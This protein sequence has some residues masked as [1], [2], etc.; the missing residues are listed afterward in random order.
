MIKLFKRLGGHKVNKQTVDK[1][2]LLV[3]AAGR[4]VQ[5]ARDNL[6]K[7]EEIYDYHTRRY[8]EADK[9][10]ARTDGRFQTVHAKTRRAAKTEEVR[11][12]DLTKEQ[13]RRVLDRIEKM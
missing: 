4:D 12:E 10:L 7:L 5:Q 3:I 6:K 13:L 9:E 2:R 11:L 8:E 1:L